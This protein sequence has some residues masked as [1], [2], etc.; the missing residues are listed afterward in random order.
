MSISKRILRLVKSDIH[1]ILDCLEDPRSILSQAIRDM[2]DE[3]RLTHSRLE[4][5][6]NEAKVVTT[7]IS[8]VDEHLR[9]VKE[10][11]NLCFDSGNELLART[12]VRKRL[13]L[14]AARAQLETAKCSS[15]KEREKLA[16]RLKEQEEKFASIKEKQAIFADVERKREHHAPIDD[17]QYISEERVEV[18]MLEEYKKRNRVSQ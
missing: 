3:I 16:A 13:E 4:V 5:T 10:Q 17:A 1:E 14:E 6:E 12:F 8:R 2:E 9:D 7:T 11:I 18:A 15:Q